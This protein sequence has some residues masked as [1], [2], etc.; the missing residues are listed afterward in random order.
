MRICSKLNVLN[1]LG[2]VSRILLKVNQVLYGINIPH[3]T[4]I[5][6]GLFL[7]HYGNIIINPKT[8]IGSNCNIAQGVTIGQT[9]R[10]KRKGV[11][12]IGNYVWIGANAVIVGGIKVG[13]NVLISPLSFV[14]EDIPDN[15]VVMGNPAQVVS[16]NGSGGYINNI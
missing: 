6:P 2:F 14:V 9:N 7:S 4:K 5:G 11:P 3:T 13:N 15:A 10:G 8:V 1:P 16:F 12:I